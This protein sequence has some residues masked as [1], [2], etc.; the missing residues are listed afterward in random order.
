MHYLSWQT[1]CR[2][3]VE[4][5]VNLSVG[6]V[7]VVFTF[8]D[9]RWPQVYYFWKHLNQFLPHP[10]GRRS[11]TGSRIRIVRLPF[12][13]APVSELKKNGWVRYIKQDLK[14]TKLQ[15]LSGNPFNPLNPPS[16]YPTKDGT[17]APISSFLKSAGYSAARRPATNLV[18]ICPDDNLLLKQTKI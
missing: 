13:P 14:I 7:I 5:H 16:P 9:N 1:G 15:I 2:Q 18:F 11:S 3:H 10:L 12:L 8:I 4:K 6:A 17:G